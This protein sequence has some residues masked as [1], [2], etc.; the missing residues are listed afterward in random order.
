MPV[1]VNK[2]YKCA[3]CEQELFD[4]DPRDLIEIYCPECHLVHK[5]CVDTVKMF[6]EQSCAICG[7]NMIQ[8]TSSFAL[9]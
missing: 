2:S 1:E 5:E 6:N 3:K 7:G 9:V 8:A 4:E